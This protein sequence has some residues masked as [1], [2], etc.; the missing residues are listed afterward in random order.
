MKWRNFPIALSAA[1]DESQTNVESACRW[2]VE[3]GE[4]PMAL[5][6]PARAAWNPRKP[7]TK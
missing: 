6:D 5:V 7:G 3:R 1:E 2:N 4:A